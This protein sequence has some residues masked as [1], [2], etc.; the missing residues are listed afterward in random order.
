MALVKLSAKKLSNQEVEEIVLKKKNWILSYSSPL[1]IIL[2]GSAARGEMTDSSDVDLIVIYDN[3]TD[4]KKVQQELF[5][6]RPKDDWPHDLLILT[7]SDYEGQCQKG[8]GACWL[9]L[10]EGK[11]IHERKKS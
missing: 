6:K 7:E 4:L 8:G 5:S 11:L 2:F 3:S 1:K 10:T 9:A